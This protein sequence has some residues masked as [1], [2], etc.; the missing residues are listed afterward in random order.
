MRHNYLKSILCRDILHQ[1]PGFRVILDRFQVK[2]AI[3]GHFRPLFLITDPYR[4]LL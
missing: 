3:F 2:M 4:N 1:K